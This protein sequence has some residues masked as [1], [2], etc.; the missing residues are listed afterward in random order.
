MQGHKKSRVNRKEIVHCRQYRVVGLTQKRWDRYLQCSERRI[1]ISLQK[2]CKKNF[3]LL[4]DV[5][6]TWKCC[7]SLDRRGQFGVYERWRLHG[8]SPSGSTPNSK[9][10]K[11]IPQQVQEP[12]EPKGR[13]RKSLFQLEAD[14]TERENLE[15]AIA[16][17]MCLPVTKKDETASR[18]V[19]KVSGSFS[20]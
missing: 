18:P 16:N 19:V 13:S 6:W 14:W 12:R 3:Q 5:P 9:K 11:D 2:M 17:L 20:R 4:H 1:Q 10:I 7:Q 8:N 15:G